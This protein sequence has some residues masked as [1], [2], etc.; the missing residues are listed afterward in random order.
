VD[1]Y[2]KPYSDLRKPAQAKWLSDDYVKFIRFGQWRINRT[3]KGIL[4]FVTNH[5]YLDNPTFH[6][7]REQL[8]RTFTDIYLVDLHGNSLKKGR[9]R[10]VVKTRTFSTFNKA[11]L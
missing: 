2:I 10:R 5:S 6:G 4:A 8:M 1:E 9:P 7:M 3:G 11:S